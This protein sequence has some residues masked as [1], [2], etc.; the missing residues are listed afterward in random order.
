MLTTYLLPH[1]PDDVEGTETLTNL[2]TVDVSS[3]EFAVVDSTN[4][5]AENIK[6][7]VSILG[8][9]GTLESTPITEGWYP[10]KFTGFNVT[11]I[12]IVGWATIPDYA[13]SNATKKDVTVALPYLED[14]D[15]SDSNTT[16][17]GNYA[18][19]N[20]TAL[21]LTE[22]PSGLTSIGAYA[23]SYC[24]ALTSIT[25]TGTP[26]TILGSAFVECNNLTDIYVPWAEGAVSNAPWGAENA[27]IHYNS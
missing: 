9:T 12:K 6:K 1:I 7:D 4:I 11:G 13:F 14:V 16:S 3:K 18:F 26:T 17:I 8:V 25:F 2:D 27:T 20:C 15:F 21:A 5:V 10:I 24:T 22:L 19:C 23:F